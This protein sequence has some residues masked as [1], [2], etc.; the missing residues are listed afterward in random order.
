VIGRPT[1]SRLLYD[2]MIGRG[3][4]GPRFGGTS[5]CLVID[6]DDNLVHMD[7]KQL[8]TASQQYVEYWARAEE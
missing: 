7:G 1:A 5:E 3:M 2:Q 6:V 8:T 4:R